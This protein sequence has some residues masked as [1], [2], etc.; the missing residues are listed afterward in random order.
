MK[1]RS[2]I[3]ISLLFLLIIP[4]I[5]N[6]FQLFE[7][8]P[9]KGAITQP[10][11]KTFTLKDWF[12]ADYQIAEEKY[13]N[14]SFGF[15]S[16]FVRIDNQIAFSL[17]KRA[18]ANGVI[19]GKQ[20][21]LFEENYIKAF[22]G[23]DFWG[24]DSISNRMQKF[25][26]ISD[27]LKKLNKNIVL[28]F[29]AGKGSYFP[30]YFPEKYK[31]T[32]RIT[33]YH[34]YLKI[35]QEL[36]INYIDFNKYFVD[37]K[38]KSKYPLYPQYGIHWSTYGM[39]IAADSIIRY[40]EKIRNIDMPNLY[41]TKVD[42]AEANGDDYDIGDG[43]NIK[44]K[45]KS[46]QMAYPDFQVESDAGK[47][48]PSVLVIADSYY[49]GM[50]G[51]GFTKA[52]SSNHFWYY[53]KEIYPDSFE[54]P[55]ETNQVRLG[56]EINKNDVIIIMATEATLPKLGWGFIENLYDLYKGVKPNTVADSAFQQKV[57][58]LSNYIKT[59]KNWMK[60]ITEKAAKR[61]ISVDSMIM[62][63]ATWQ[64]QQDKK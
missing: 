28:V 29:A 39:G 3:F 49:W 62:I 33:N 37:N 24:Y 47:T 50:F 15:R 59:D 42:L 45:L 9:L 2:F 8:A 35:A 60:Q 43:L 36:G 13:L 40:V 61:K 32:P 7:L 14:E 46:F 18:K 27:T 57:I 63:D 64:I 10:E 56:D 11:K 21:Y 54:K 48:K 6:E 19:I 44:F 34:Y 1:A 30:E 16:L 23:T 17:F 25:K 51:F 20:N 53:N 12:S 5:Q 26:F 58:N 31:M 22:N 38:Y 55:T 4:G 41:W 52:F